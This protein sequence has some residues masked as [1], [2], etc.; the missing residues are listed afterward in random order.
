M[1]MTT[2][3]HLQRLKHGSADA[4]NWLNR[5]E[6]L[7]ANFTHA[8]E[9]ARASNA[10][11][12]ERTPAPFVNREVDALSQIMALRS[13]MP[14][15]PQRS[16]EQDQEAESRNRIRNLPQ[17]PS[18]PFLTSPTDQQHV[19]GEAMRLCLRRI[20]PNMLK[21]EVMRL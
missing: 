3:R 8:A 10:A 13:S 5:A 17:F 19:Q 16:G 12:V 4:S 21:G 1:D 20:H 14:L 9:A 6:T 2:P 7:A 11:A 18:F 15:M